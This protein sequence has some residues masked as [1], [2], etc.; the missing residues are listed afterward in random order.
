MLYDWNKLDPQTQMSVSGMVTNDLVTLSQNGF[1]VVHLYLWDISVLR[2]FSSQT[3]PDLQGFC[4]DI[5]DPGPCNGNGDPRNSPD[6]TG[7]PILWDNLD[8]FLTT[9]ENDGIYVILE[10]ANG[11][12]TNAIEKNTLTCSAIEQTYTTW[13]K[14]FIDHF[15]ANHNNILA[16]GLN[17]G[18]VPNG[19]YPCTNTMW[20]QSYNFVKSE[21]MAYYPAR[22]AQAMV[23]V[24]LGLNMVDPSNPNS[25]PTDVVARGSGYT[26]N[27]TWSV[28]PPNYGSQQMAQQMYTVLNNM[29]PDYFFLGGYNPNNGDFNSALYNLI[30]TSTSGG[31]KVPADKIVFTEFGASSGLTEATA[32]RPELPAGWYAYAS[33]PDNQVPITT[34]AG[35]NQW[36]QNAVCAFQAA[37]IS[38]QAYWNM[39][40]P[41]T[42]WSS[43]SWNENN[44]NWLALQGFWGL[45][46]ED[47][48][49]YKD[50]WYKLESFYNN[51]LSCPSP[52][53]GSPALSVNLDATYYTVNQP[54]GF[55]W[56]VTDGTSL[57]LSQGHNGS[58][59]CVKGVIISSSNLDGD[60]AYTV[61][62]GFTSSGNQTI[63]MTAL[64]NLGAPVSSGA[65]VEVGDGP[66]ISAI[67]D[68]NYNSYITTS[69]IIILWGKGFA[70]HG[71]N[72][73][74]LHNNTTGLDYWLYEA[75]GMYYAR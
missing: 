45:V 36:V 34:R 52:A 74:Q 10:F 49:T 19:Q 48:A 38:K 18:W 20:A 14:Y 50:A 41:Y 3:D 21:A 30:N 26:F 60:C 27:W 57:S 62:S 51:T 23:G 71:G 69:S 11:Q 13:T 17:W 75:D 55:Y 42:Y 24:A 43:P 66:I 70:I 9:A 61:A 53:A 7:R 35:Q 44:Y 25:F 64:S 67:T 46:T 5:S 28:S 33:L 37:G 22:P 59:S 6:A 40:D 73:I 56:T 1:N 29:E 68:S 47:T 31:R 39:Y 16:W 12:V 4:S 54:I 15:E 63:T 72:T 58:Y 65:T 32:D 8:Q 2:N